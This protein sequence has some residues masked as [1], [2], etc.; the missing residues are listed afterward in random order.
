MG[1]CLCMSIDNAQR[2]TVY[3]WI[4]QEL[5]HE[6]MND[7]FIFL[8]STITFIIRN[9]L[10]IKIIA[11]YFNKSE[12]EILIEPEEDICKCQN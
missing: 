8:L 1:H 7:M 12:S 5:K 2:F 6:W 10:I 9:N 4:P 11:K 3:E